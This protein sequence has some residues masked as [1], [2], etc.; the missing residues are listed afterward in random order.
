MRPQIID[1]RFGPKADITSLIDH[2]VGA[3]E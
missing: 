2:R 1:V 3:G